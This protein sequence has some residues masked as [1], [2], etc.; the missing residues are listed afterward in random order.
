MLYQMW[1]PYEAGAFAMASF[2]A[3][4]TAAIAERA[5]DTDVRRLVYLA[6]FLSACAAAMD[7]ATTIGGLF[8][9]RA[10]L[11]RTKRN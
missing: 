4:A 6:T 2:F 1:L 3:L 9:Y 7:L 11:S 8:Q 5:A 10:A